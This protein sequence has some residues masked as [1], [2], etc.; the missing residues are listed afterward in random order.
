M[1]YEYGLELLKE[2]AKRS[3]WY[4][5]V[6][7]YEERLLS[8]L[9]DE[10]LYGPAQQ[11]GQERH[12]VAHQLNRLCI[13][14]LEVSFNDLCQGIVSSPAS[15]PAQLAR[16]LGVA[17]CLCSRDD[18]FFY[19]KL[20]ASLSLWQQ[21]SKLAWLE[22]EAGDDIARTRQEHL[23]QANL[24]LLLCSS[25]FFADAACYEAMMAAL[26]EHARRQVPVVPILVRACAWEESA[27]GHLAVLPENKQPI[28]EWAQP[29]Q[30]YESI[31]RS[32][33]RL[34]SGSDET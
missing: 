23:R 20:Q 11:T 27:C 33:I 32:L 26:Q 24:V 16:S 18:E 19:R 29:D 1:D 4:Q 7:P 9:Q 22:I 3:G 31:R 6:L 28:N 14:H 12:R 13:Q 8:I 5:E 2:I 17:I 21:Q 30:A 34:F 15:S 10:Q 25:S